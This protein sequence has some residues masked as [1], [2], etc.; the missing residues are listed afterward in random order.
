MTPTDNRLTFRRRFL[1]CG[2]TL[3]SKCSALRK[4]KEK[5]FDLPVTKV[6]ETIET[7]LMLSKK[8]KNGVLFVVVGATPDGTFESGKRNNQKKLAKGNF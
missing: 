4:R 8:T 5:Q 3:L 2:L 1:T 7:I 6:D